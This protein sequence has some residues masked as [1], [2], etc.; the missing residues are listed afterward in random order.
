MYRQRKTIGLVLAVASCCLTT[1]VVAQTVTVA[2]A[3][4]VEA[5]HPHDHYVHP[6]P[7]AGRPVDLVI[8][9]DTS[10]SMTGLI[11]TARAKL[12][13]VVS[14]LVA[15]E[16]N[17]RLRVGLLTYGSPGVSTAAEGWIVRQSDLSSDLDSVY[18][19]MMSMY[20]D[21]G[22]EFVGWVLSDA[23]HTLNWSQDPRA[24]RLIYVSGNESADQCSTRFNFRQIA[25]DARRKG[26]AINAIY[27][28]PV[29]NGIAEHWDQVATHGGGHFFAIDQDCGTQQFATPQ[30]KLLIELNAQLNAT[31]VPYGAAGRAGKANQIAQDRNAASFG[32]QSIA[33]RAQTKA[34]AVYQNRRWD[35]VD[36]AD[37]PGFDLEQVPEATLP[38]EMQKMS[39]QQRREYIV[40]KRTTR[41]RVRQQIRE[42]TTKREATLRKNRAARK[43]KGLD[44]AMRESVRA[45]AE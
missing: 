30:D 1:W 37:D 21:G 5:A 3:A 40:E 33:S 31:Y 4:R 29:T 7:Q 25:Q 16:P 28:G 22:E 19:K 27:A 35:L 41:A 24:L 11:D 23:V 39:K 12:W 6:Y 18:A 14:E 8:C 15:V 20:P 2:A 44:D 45:H 38:P 10:G 9:L 17:A 34:S 43:T 36:A 26:I 42:V 13:D 32:Q